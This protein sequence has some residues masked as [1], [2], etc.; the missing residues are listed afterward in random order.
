MGVFALAVPRVPGYPTCSDSVIAR[1]G[2]PYA[3]DWLDQPVGPVSGPGVGERAFVAFRVV[4]KP[5]DPHARRGVRIFAVDA[6]RAPADRVR[7][8]RARLPGPPPLAARSLNLEPRLRAG[9]KKRLSSQAA[10]LLPSFSPCF[11]ELRKWK[12]SQTRAS[13]TWFWMSATVSKCCV[14]VSTV[15]PFS[16]PGM[17]TSR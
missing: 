10:T 3:A 15:L 6:A 17:V 9:W 1:T 12:P 8:R 16:P 2:S 14:V 13:T 7:Y 11:T 4:L 5:D